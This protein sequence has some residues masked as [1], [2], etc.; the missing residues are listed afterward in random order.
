MVRP[1]ISASRAIVSSRCR[2]VD[3]TLISHPDRKR[4]FKNRCRC[5]MRENCASFQWQLGCAPTQGGILDVAPAFLPDEVSVSANSTTGEEEPGMTY[6]VRRPAAPTIHGD[7]KG[8]VRTQSRRYVV[9]HADDAFW[10]RPSKPSPELSLW[11][12]CTRPVDE[13]LPMRR[14]RSGP[15]SKNWPDE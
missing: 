15:N 1:N 3:H 8:K 6:F 2:H 11:T 5:C 7:K 13:K 10:R 9:V 4:E 12:R 14:Q